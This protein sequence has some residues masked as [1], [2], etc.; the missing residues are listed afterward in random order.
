MFRSVIEGDELGLNRALEEIGFFSNTIVD[1]QRQAVLNLVKM[2]CEP[3]LV[4]GQYDFKKSDLAKRLRE[5]RTILSMEQEYWHT[6]P[7]DALFL[8]R[9]IGGMY[10]LAA[11]IGA[12]VNIRQL[13][14]PYLKVL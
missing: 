1:S 3:M 14:Q 2:A 13:V 5:A 7:A 8:H 4:E 12:K 11:R 9:K 6:P 10:M